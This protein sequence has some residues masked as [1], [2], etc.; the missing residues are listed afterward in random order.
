MPSNDFGKTIRF[1][2]DS[3]KLNGGFW[4]SVFPLSAQNLFGVVTNQAAAAT[5][6]INLQLGNIFSITFT[7]NTV[8]AIAVPTNGVAGSSLG[9]CDIWIINTS[10]GNLTNLTFNASIKQPSLTFPADT[11]RRRYSLTLLGT[12]WYLDYFSV[13]DVPN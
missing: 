1:T 6:A 3:T 8:C 5:P 11:N 9:T 12:T 10:G 13:A 7:A 4:T 2:Q